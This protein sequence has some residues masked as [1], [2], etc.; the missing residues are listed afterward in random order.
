MF[1]RLI[2]RSFSSS[3]SSFRSIRSTKSSLKSF[4][5]IDRTFETN[6]QEEN[7][8]NVDSMKSKIDPLIS[9]E[10]EIYLKIFL[11]QDEKN[12]EVASGEG[13]E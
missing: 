2:E 4:D 9:I 1:I 5:F 11:K 3:F 8:T 10:I 6:F 7:E 12:L 13:E